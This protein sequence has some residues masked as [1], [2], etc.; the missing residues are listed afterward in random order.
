MK[1]ELV[2]QPMNED[3]FVF[4]AVTKVGRRKKQTNKKNV[5]LFEFYR[6][7]EVIHSEKKELF[8]EMFVSNRLFEIVER[9]TV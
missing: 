1:E 4:L 9:S 6:S 7:K 3:I 2:V 8:R 5:C